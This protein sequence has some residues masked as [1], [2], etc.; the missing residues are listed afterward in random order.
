MAITG[1]G[2]EMLV[3]RLGIQHADPHDPHAGRLTRTYGSYDVYIDA[4]RQFG[5]FVCE[6][7]GPGNPHPAPPHATDWY[8][9]PQGPYPL[10]TQVG[11]D[12]S[13]VTKGY[14]LEDRVQRPGVLL[15]STAPRSE[16]LIHPGHTPDLFLSS[17]GCLNPTSA[18]QPRQC[19]DFADSRDH[20]I[21]IIESLKAFSPASFAAHASVPIPNARV[22]IVGEPMM[23]YPA[24]LSS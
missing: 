21:Q 1:H 18:L 4:V 12:Y 3:Q 13:Y 19:M 16:I 5:G 14:Q 10:S 2:W 11:D 7:P 15:L 17:I 24:S 9:I 20:V 23:D 22:I 8:R 6:S